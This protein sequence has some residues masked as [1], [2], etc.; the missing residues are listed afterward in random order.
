MEK[1]KTIIKQIKKQTLDLKG[2]VIMSNVC[3]SLLIARH[4]FPNCY[5]C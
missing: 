5:I 2:V 4:S 1:I 3:E